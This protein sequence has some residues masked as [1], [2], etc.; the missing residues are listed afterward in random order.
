MANPTITL[1]GRLAND[2]ELRFTRD[3]KPVASFS[4]V[5]SDSRK[6]G[7][8]WEDKDTS[9]WR[10]TAWDKQ[11]EH[12]ASSLTKGMAVIAVA[13]MRER[14]YET[15]E[16]EKRKSVEF[17][18]SAIGPSLRFQIAS[19]EKAQG[20]AGRAQTQNPSQS[21]GQGGWGPG[22]ASQAHQQQANGGWPAPGGD[23]R[24]DD[25]EPPF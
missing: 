2:V 11:A 19:V 8:Q 23:S 10:C 13:K 6:N 15:R 21:A 24:Y 1:E 18:V 7:D 4:I 12:A 25:S 17:T 5:T 3:G 9:Y 14:E 16:G 22:E 20:G